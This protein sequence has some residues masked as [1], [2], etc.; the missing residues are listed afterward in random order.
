MLHILCRAVRMIS[1][2]P[3]PTANPETGVMDGCVGTV[4][5]HSVFSAHV[6]TTEL[7]TRVL[8]YQYAQH[9]VLFILNATSHGW[10]PPDAMGFAKT[11]TVCLSPA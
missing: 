10:K 3:S 9:D 5:A 1:P 2:P 4:L 7:S 6:G 11:F 8:L